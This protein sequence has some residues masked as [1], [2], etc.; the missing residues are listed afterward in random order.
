MCPPFARC[1]LA[2][3]FLI[4]LL[5]VLTFR[6]EDNA[7]GQLRG[8]VDGKS[9]IVRTPG[10]RDV[11]VNFDDGVRL[12]R[13]VPAGNKNSS[14]SFNGLFQLESL[15]DQFVRLETNF[16]TLNS[17]ALTTSTFCSSSASL[18]ADDPTY[19]RANTS[20]TGTGTSCPSLGGAGADAVPYDVYEFEI[21]GCSS[22]QII[23]STCPDSVTGGSG[24]TTAGMLDT[25]L[26]IYRTDGTTANLKNGTGLA[27]AFD[28]GSACTNVVAANDN[29]TATP[30]SP[31]G[32]SCDQD[33]T[34]DCMPACSTSTT[35]SGL[36]RTIGPGKFTVVVAG[37]TNTT[38]GNYNLF[39]KT[40]NSACNLAQISAC[41]TITVDPVSIPRSV[42]INTPYP[43][44]TFTASGSSGLYTF[45]ATGV[46]P[47]M[48]FDT[49]N[50]KLS[51]TP[52]QAGGYEVTIKASDANGCSGSH[53]YPIVVTDPLLSCITDELAAGDPTYNRPRAD[54]SQTS[55]MPAAGCSLMGTGGTPLVNSHYKAYEFST[56]CTTTVTA[57]LC[58]P[59]GCDPITNSTG[60]ADSVISLYRS[61]GD[62]TSGSG[63]ANPFD[64][65]NP[66]QHLVAI[67]DA[68][69]SVEASSGGLPTCSRP[70]LS[71]FTRTIG[72]G[73]FVIVVTSGATGE[74]G[75]YHLNVT[76]SSCA[77]QQDTKLA[78][79][80]QPTN[81]SP[82]TAISP[83]VSVQLRDN[84]GNDIPVA[85][86]PIT[87]A[88]TSGTGVLSG[89]LTQNTNSAGRAAFNNLSV[90]QGGVKRLTASS[91]GRDSAVSSTFTVGV[92]V[93]AVADTYNTNEDTAL[94]VAAPGVLGNDI[95]SPSP[96]VMAITNGTTAQGGAVTVK[97]DGSFSYTPP[98]NFKSAPT[99]SFTYTAT[100]GSTSDT[101]TVTITVN[102][103][104]DPPVLTN[105]TTAEDTLS[106]AG[107][108]TV[109][110]S[111]LDGAEVTHFKI[112]AITNGTLFKSDGITPIAVNSFITAAEGDAGVRFLPSNNLNSSAGDAF[113]FSVSGA[114]S[115]A[116]AGLGN[117]STASITV[118]EVN[119][120]P[121]PTDDAASD[122]AEDSGLYSIPTSSLLA[123]DTKG[124]ANESGQTLK[125]LSVANPAGGTIQLNGAIIEFSPD[126]NFNGLAG[127]DYTVQ[128]NG[129][130][131]GNPDPKTATAHVNFNVNAV[132]DPLAGAAP[133]TV[134]DV[135]EDSV[136]FAITGMTISDVDVALAPAGVYQ[137][138][139]SSTHGKMTL[140]T[141]AGLTFTVG[142]GA[143]DAS[144]TFHG[145]L[146]AINTGL[147]TASYTPDADY[148]GSAEI[149][150]EATDNFGGTV[151][152]GSGSA[153]QDSDT[154]NVTV[155]AVNDAPTLANN[156][157]LTVN[158]GSTGTV[159]DNTK[160]KV[161]DVDNIAA[162]R[163]FTVVTPPA[164]GTL[165]KGATPL[166]NSSTFTQEDIDNSLI[167]YDHNGSET[168]GDSFT[169]TYDDG[170]VSPIGP[171]TFNI[172]VTP[173]N[174]APQIQ[175]NNG[176]NVTSGA[177][178]TIDSTRLS[179]TDTDNTAAQLTY[180]I[181]TA[182]AHGQ[183]KKSG[184]N[185]GSGGTF[186]Q[187]DVDNN[188]ITFTHNGDSALTDSF[189]FTVS[190]GA[191]GT[192]GTTT[193]N[194]T[195][196]C[197]TNGIVTNSNDS[198]PG[199]LRDALITS[200]VGSVITFNIPTDGSDP[201]Y[202]S[203]TGVF[204]ITLTSGE[205][206]IDRNLTITGLGANVLRIKRSTA[207]GT[208]RFRIFNIAAG[209]ITANISG[210]TMTNGRTADGTPGSGNGVDA[211]GIL[212]D[213]GATL[214]LKNVTVS[215]NI[216]GDGELTAVGGDGGN[217]GGIINRG[218]LT[219][220]NSTVSGNSAGSSPGP[221][222]IGGK[223]GG[224][225]N[226]GTLT[227]TNTTISNNKAGGSATGAGGQ[228]GGIFNNAG[229]ALNLISSTISANQS[230]SGNSSGDGGGICNNG[231]A[232]VKNSILA[233]NT[234]S[235]SGQGQ[236]G[237]GIL[238]SQDYNF[239]GTL[240]GIGFTTVIGPHDIHDVPASLSTLANNGG[241]TQ[242][243]LP[244]PGS[245]ALNA[246][247]AANLPADTSDADGDSNTGEQLPVDQR[248]F[249]RVVGTNADIG[250]VEANYSV[251][252][253]AGTPQSAVIDTAFA[254]NLEATVT[255]SGI[256][257]NNL[258]V[259]F[260]AGSAGGATGAFP[261]NSSTANA[262]TN[263]SGIATAP[264]FTAN[265]T[266]GG[267]YDVTAS[268]GTGLPIAT[269]ALTNTK[270]QAQVNLSN[271]I[272]TYD[273]TPKSVT[274][275][276][277]PPG[278]T[279]NITY[280][281]SSTPPTNVKRDG[282]GNVI[283]YAVVATVVDAN[284]QGT[285]STTL[286]INKAASI[287]TVTANNATFDGNPHGGTATVTGAGGL[288]QTLTVTYT[289][290]NGTT[291]GPSTTAPT[292]AGDYTASTSFAGDANHTSSNNSKDFQIAKADQIITFNALSDK[293]FGDAQFTASATGSGS[294]NAVTFNSTTPSVCATGG[295]N[296]STITIVG[297]GACTITAAQAGNA[298]Y[299]A[300]PSVQRSFN[301]DK[302]G[303]T[304]NITVS[305][306]T[307]DGLPH[308]G[309]AVVTGAGGLN[310]TLDVTYTGRNGTTYGPST[311][312]PTSAGGYTAAATFNGDANHNGSSDSKDFSIARAATTTT[313]MSSFNPSALGQSVTFK[314][315]VVSTVGTPSGT[316]QF[317]DGA[318]DLGTAALNA[319][320]VAT[321]TT[322][323]LTSGNHPITATYNGATNFDVSTGTLTGGQTVAIQSS[324]SINKVSQAEGNTGTT[325][326]V[327]TVT[328]SQ[329]SDVAVTVD[330]AT[331]DGTGAGAATA[332]GDYTAQT[333]TLTFN[334][335]DLTK[336]IT[337]AVNGDT[338]NEADEQFKVTLSNLQNVNAG[339]LN[340]DGT[341][342]NDDAPTVQLGSASYSINEGSNNTPQGF[343]TLSV[344]VVRSGDLSQPMTVRYTT[345]DQSAGNECDQ[346]TGFAS[347][348]CDYTLVGA[349]LRFSA[350]EGTKNIIIPVTNDGYKE[351]DEIFSVQ[352][353]SPVGSI[354]G[355]IT[356]AT[357]TISDDA[358]DATPTTPQQNPYL[359]NSFFVRQDY[360]DNLGRDADQAGFN[361]WTNVLNNCGPQ[362]GFLGAPP[363]CDRAHVAHGFFGS[364][365]FT[366][367]G[368]LLFRLYEVGRGRLPLYREF[369]PDMATLSSFGLSDSAR[370]QN[371]SDYLQQFSSDPGF[372]TRFQSVS[373]PS[374]AVQL[375]QMLEQAA[376]V[377]LPQTTA[378]LPGQP[379]QYGRSELIQKRQT[380]QF[381]LIE[382]VKA[383]V[384]QKAVYDRYF[385]EGE[386]TMMYFVYLRRDPDLNDP[387]LVGW[388]DWVQVFT[389]G[390]ALSDGTVIEPRDIH[391]LI[392]GF[393]YSTE[394]RKRFG[395]P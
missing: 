72:P 169:F 182:P 156:T 343:T 166:V 263:S 71:G 137:V 48:S 362:K 165:Y 291:Y 265:S 162:E 382:T 158:E 381:S 141:T 94:N 253:T 280:D 348:R 28:A 375:L 67:N 39:V 13:L 319:S 395:T 34:S 160:L 360:L 201:G 44:Q 388:N 259:T 119:D 337:V 168:I 391:H 144:M 238:T 234:V 78:F 258:L 328:L 109:N 377:T 46:P 12:T 341:I 43:T 84:N 302:A 157:T 33:N 269:F 188:R 295:I 210:I 110:R 351:G 308:G 262:T 320:G 203:G 131:A 249:T 10:G 366:T 133:A 386:V 361:D 130:T 208:P 347:Q 161:D 298:N 329:A 87:V 354:L 254:A 215:G 103:V 132:N 339:D 289:G 74:T 227:L 340:G 136:N 246:V 154:I 117:S 224:I 325:N 51:G 189:T 3:F 135:T 197:V 164:N 324:I 129:T 125:V 204:T 118:T 66:C 6:L 383:F 264:Q 73:R 223:G 186:T 32:S 2:T 349:T 26:F 98:P 240:S 241:P 283:G 1:F 359:S 282:G 385:T 225:F 19:H 100:N 83:A 278:L 247:P 311:T 11:Q 107:L 387:N 63:A 181:G 40:V 173:Q 322:S 292:N 248:G 374:Q 336:S 41:P 50:H 297:V 379:P 90:D 345:S 81:S 392:F 79:V 335:G 97:S 60:L 139:L 16:L 260:T 111:A 230:G 244:L 17:P 25:Q 112:T 193:F 175:S 243:I 143:A 178:G 378:T 177:T 14:L 214:N 76:S 222:G 266:T 159:I 146:S 121:V 257:R 15:T 363:A 312:A 376:Q 250:A 27:G 356:Q 371:L 271:I 245:P 70:S 327:F 101:A 288:N 126:P 256:A 228:G 251:T 369:V 313:V 199:S 338:A 183:L 8:S 326:F 104:A 232:N 59:A 192:I 7:S 5:L 310:Q 200:C 86:V 342:L 219:L 93:D 31:G 368:F 299:N 333:G 21:T 191:G 284:Y 153:T 45:S 56:S 140:T 174:N 91:A 55:G 304:T 64:P 270:A 180:T 205:L 252:A 30:R 220:T 35:L 47:G 195:I 57:S 273:G 221:S 95:G 155:Q 167:K 4:A 115:A 96:S 37:G 323:A 18:D 317:K 255:E 237:F 127:F 38:F 389:N 279:L 350:G 287:T 105:A 231:I 194:I 364:D 149:K 151:A 365:E 380:G 108:L 170:V 92:P 120:V 274:A 196:G 309:T 331:S 207:G 190:D 290:R 305:N 142:D 53:L 211:G 99:D 58:G 184:S 49:V 69:N 36:K 122:I 373:Q 233:G 318:T 212:N 150:L 242:T 24:C 226:T 275:G 145:T 102:P 152:T 272:Q 346:L 293:I 23:V 239:Y 213:T 123:N 42:K 315:T 294:G 393:I 300:A 198:G 344:D 314:A 29:L 357:V 286:T 22:T 52:T 187:D 202:D 179:V 276:T 147:A 229:A 106:G 372:I 216:A 134:N 82:N 209:A 261:G 384:E 172:T 176:L 65:N 367:S 171:A 124:P 85:G 352:L 285:T 358:A 277:V 54:D 62:L 218:T 370:Q 89:T 236:D 20:A 390:G 267:S 321:L 303:S 332:P 235:G 61:T 307:F 185:L 301:V 394:Y 75:A 281:G 138:T 330:F 296:G 316:V 217:G 116:G 113:S 9:T 268:I 306:A 148:N 355:S 128:D 88:M 353:S 80:Q 114:T 206:L 68:L 334:P 77:L 163:K